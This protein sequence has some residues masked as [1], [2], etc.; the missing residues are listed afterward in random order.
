MDERI[1][2]A[3]RDGDP[4]AAV[5]PDALVEAARLARP[6]VDGPADPRVLAL[7]ASLHWVRHHAL[8]P[9][10]AGADLDVCLNLSGPLTL[11][12]PGSVPRPVLDWFAAN[13]AVPVLALD[14]V[15]R[16][17]ATVITRAAL[18]M[19]DPELV[20]AG[21]ELCRAAVRHGAERGDEDVDAHRLNLLVLL[22]VRHEQRGEPADLDEAV[23]TGRAVRVP[24]DHPLALPVALNLGLALQYRFEAAGQVADLDGAADLLRRARSLP[25]ED[26]DRL[27]CLFALGAA[28]AARCGRGAPLTEVEE[29]VEVAREV[30]AAC[31]PDQPGRRAVLLLLGEALRIRFVRTGEAAD[32]ADVDESARCAAEALAIGGATEEEHVTALLRL[33]TALVLRFAH[34]RAFG[35]PDEEGLIGADLAGADLVEATRL[36]ALADDAVP[37]GHPLRPEVDAVLSTVRRAGRRDPAGAEQA[38]RAA[39]A[40]STGSPADRVGLVFSLADALLMRYDDTGNPVLLHEAADLLRRAAADADDRV[41]APVLLTLA[42]VARERFGL[43]GAEDDLDEAVEAMR[44]AALVAPDDVLRGHHLGELTHLLG[45]RHDRTGR[46]A[47]LDERIRALRSLTHLAADDLVRAECLHRLATALTRRAELTGDRADLDGAVDAADRAADLLPDDHP[48]LPRVLTAGSVVRHL[49]ADVG[50]EPGAGDEPD[51]RVVLDSP[52]GADHPAVPDDITAAVALARR[53]LDLCPADDPHFPFAQV[54]LAAVLGARARARHD[55]DGTTESIA[56]CREVLAHDDGPTAFA[57]ITLGRV[58]VGRYAHTRAAAELDEAVEDT[59]RAAERV[60]AELPPGHRHVAGLAVNTAALLA[61]RYERERDPADLDRAVTLLRSAP[62][63]ARPDHPAPPEVR[64]NLGV[65]LLLRFQR[66]T[67]ATDLDEAIASLRAAAA[68]GGRGSDLVVLQLGA[69]LLARAQWS[70]T[71]EAHEEA[72]ALLR[73]ARTRFRRG[74]PAHLMA[75]V[76]LGTA[77]QLRYNDT[78]DPAALAEAVEVARTAVRTGPPDF[79]YRVGMLTLLGTVLTQ[80]FERTDDPA[81][82][83]EAVEAHRE[84]VATPAAN[85]A[86]SATALA[87]L[88]NSLRARH[89]RLTDPADLD[90]AIAVARRAAELPGLTGV[91]RAS[92]TATLADGLLARGRRTGAPAD[93]SAAVDLSRTAVAGVPT[94]YFLAPAH[95]TTLGVALWT[96]FERTGSLADL[97][98]AI[99]VLGAA[100]TNRAAGSLRSLTLSNLSNALRARAGL[101]GSSGDLDAAVDT[102]RAAVADATPASAV[103][104]LL[105]LSVALHVRAAERQDPA[106]LDA[107]IPVAARAVEHCPEEHP[108]RPQVLSNLAG[109]LRT[110][111]ESHPRPG[112]LD[113]AVELLREAVARTDPAHATAPVHRLNLSVALRA[114]YADRGREEDAAEAVDLARRAVEALPVDDPRRAVVWTNLGWV[115]RLRHRRR[116]DR[117][118]SDHAATTA[119]DRSTGHAAAAADYS[120]AGHTAATATGHAAADHT[121]ATTAAATTDPL[122]AN[123]AAAA[124]HATAD[125]IAATAAAAADRTAAATAATDHAAATAAYRAA[126][127]FT[128]APALVRVPAAAG[129]ALLS[130]DRADWASAVEGFG[131]VV[132]L[133]PQLAWHGAERGARERR[134]GRW[135]GL[136]AAGAAAA[137]EAGDPDRA[138]E[139]LEQGRSVLWAQVLQ[140]RTDMS[141]L[142]ERDPALHDRLRAVAAE[143]A[144]A[145]APDGPT[146]LSP[147]LA[148]GF[149]HDDARHEQAHRIRLAGEWDR[150]L[151]RARALPGLAHLLRVPPLADLRDG[152]PDGPVVLLNLHERR[153]DALVVHRDRPVAHVP[154]PD[155]SLSEATERT[156]AYLH[157]LRVLDAPNS[158]GGRAGARQ[159]LPATLEWLWD[160]VAEP[161]LDHLGPTGGEFRLWWCPTGPLTLLPLHAAGYHDPADTP[162]GRTVLDR[163]VSSYTPTLRALARAGTTGPPTTADR[164][165]L[166]VSLPETPP[167]PGTEALSPLPGARAEAEFFRRVLP[168]AHT[169]RVGEEATRANVTADLK[170]HAYAHFACHGGQDLR[171]PSTG[172]LYLRDGPLTVLDVAGLD[173]AHA[174][175]AYLSACRTAVGGTTLPDE[176]IHLAAALQLAGYRHVI[177]TLWTV[178]DRTAVEVAT[179]VYSALL[180]DAGPHG[181]GAGAGAGPRAADLDLTDTAHVLH[182]TVRALRDAAPR[183]PTRWAPYVHS[184]P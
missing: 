36:S 115:L 148:P 111:A 109:L 166:V 154:L 55:P 62:I 120:A 70:P 161:V 170:T 94:G 118:R 88:S 83:A 146:G 107:A 41:P 97:H 131:T 152:L 176:S 21:A 60:L 82:L 31:G 157:A 165:V 143:L 174:Q 78:G 52:V 150:L 66:T 129:W 28:L 33:A 90:E 65:V 180:G 158:P 39:L 75:L 71:P 124:G 122:A 100:A 5:A 30:A 175:L 56:L 73:H 164:R 155:L 127:Q 162:A 37:A 42:K 92:T 133:L 86:A 141:V 99:D 144:D 91:E 117:D 68:G 153:C 142:H 44:A 77:L 43:S 57:V 178:A 103:A 24:A 2:L 79:A 19:G 80:L 130:A 18:A 136:A 3:V 4:A 14:V 110:R 125:H 64:L 171:D 10:E 104:C 114:R 101:L 72:V 1:T 183:D 47:D 163:V 121:A 128:A 106:D 61:G 96:R 172:A 108:H 177:A 105:N 140:T 87:E 27:S 135:Q 53:A 16:Y 69:A 48:A 67:E 159:T 46:R 9:E 17:Y 149:P 63:G 139:L 35:R 54:A 25:P 160:A 102:G 38:A 89:H 167:T 145:D 85:P 84:A 113:R 156:N 184:G 23:E 98:E 20:D 74:T 138:V 13:P 58:L 49:R 51:S 59:V 151:A 32:V 123:H 29:C 119:T 26:T 8:P 50:D 45:L 116:R 173:L 182:R 15:G 134:L 40:A 34:A 7:L 76:H 126:A 93:L 6:A 168:G 112:D 12:A 169:P 181:A 137:V 132:A 81:A 179:A 95:L 22:R 11:V 147:V